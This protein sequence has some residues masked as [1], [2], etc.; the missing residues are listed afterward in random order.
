MIKGLTHTAVRVTDMDAALDF[1]CGKLG[2]QEQ[3]RL[4]R[5]D[6][7]LWLVYLRI[8]DRQFI[9]LF[10]GAEK[11]YERT[12][13]AGPVHLCLEVED[14]HAAHAELLARG[15]SPHSEPK[16]GADGAWQFW[17]NDPGGNPIE[18]QQFTERSM[19]VRGNI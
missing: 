17:T 18:F 2:L 6:G 9:E 3:F 13:A 19:H 7:S 5:D 15:G 11:P 14:I 16:L 8:A 1:Y 12:S 10:P 4:T